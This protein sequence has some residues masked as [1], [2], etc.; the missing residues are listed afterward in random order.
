VIETIG[1]LFQHFMVLLSA[2]LLICGGAL[3]VLYALFW[4]EPQKENRPVSRSDSNYARFKKLA[5]Q[6]LQPLNRVAK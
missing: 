3:S 6:L 2:V 4:K 1:D 5:A